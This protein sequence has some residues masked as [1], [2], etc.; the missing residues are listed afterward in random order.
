MVELNVASM[1]QIQDEFKRRAMVE[2]NSKVKE[3]VME[4]DRAYNSGKITNIYRE[5]K[6]KGTSVEETKYCVFTK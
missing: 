1:E 3:L 6:N 2:H 4:I 5:V